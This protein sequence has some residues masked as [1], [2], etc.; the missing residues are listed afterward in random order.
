MREV[1]AI[2]SDRLGPV[3]ARELEAAWKDIGQW[4]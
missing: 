2:V 1:A 3:K 4:R